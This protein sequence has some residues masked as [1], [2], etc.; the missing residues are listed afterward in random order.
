MDKIWLLF[1]LKTPLNQCQHNETTTTRAHSWGRMHP[2]VH[3][4]TLPVWYEHTMANTHLPVH[5]DICAYICLS[6][7]LSAHFKLLIKHKLRKTGWESW[8]MTSNSQC[9]LGDNLDDV[10]RNSG[11]PAWTSQS[12]S[13]FMSHDPHCPRAGN[14]ELC[15]SLRG[16]HINFVLSVCLSIRLSVCPSGRP[17]RILCTQLSQ[18]SSANSADTWWGYPLGMSNELIRVS[19]MW[20]NFQGHQGSKGHKPK[21]FLWTQYRPKFLS[22]FDETLIMH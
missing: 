12:T 8:G 2:R 20:P 21:P 9:M 1:W 19:P 11:S 3:T 5:P 14:F 7:C 22:D 4:S 13:I 15:L 16:R 10:T 17:S 6:M 18:N